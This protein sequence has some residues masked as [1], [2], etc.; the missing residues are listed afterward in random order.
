[1]KIAVT[2]E[3]G[4]VFQ[5]FG[6]TENFKIYEME[7]GEILS[8]EIV[9]TDGTGH[10]ALAA[11][12]TDNGVSGL[13]C[14]G[15]G[16]G[17]ADALAMAGISVFSGT[18]G[19]A[20]D[21]VARFLSGE[22]VNAGVNCDH[23]HE[24]GHEH[25]HSC[26]HGHEDGGCGGHDDGGCD[27]EGGCGGCHGGCGGGEMQFLFE[28]KNVGKK[29]RVHYRGTYDDGEQFDASYDRGEPLEFICGAGMMIMGFDKA[30]AEM[31]VGDVV[32]VHLMP[33]EA[34][35]ERQDRMVI[36]VQKATVQGSE[37]LSVGDRVYL[38][39]ELG[40]PFPALVT[41]AD[42]TNITFD[43]NHE[44]AGKELNFRIELVEIM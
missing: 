27:C 4:K 14:G 41:E 34:Y 37:D 23:H 12:L 20:D 2:Y 44:M 13:I 18:T 3:D 9:N 30:V 31:E 25:G 42:D 39:D 40:R 17:A 1:M 15:M 6:H 32:D 19:D 22:L 21:A 11:W 43:C 35:G 10:E 7:N 26:G 33:G 8:S 5:H 16:Q 38:T 29:V 24:H 36:T 28:G